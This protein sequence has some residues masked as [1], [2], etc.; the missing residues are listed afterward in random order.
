MKR[1][2]LRRTERAVVLIMTVLVLSILVLV[3]YAFSYGAGVNSAAARNVRDAARLDAGAQSA[4]N[5]ACSMLLEKKDVR[6]PDTLGDAWNNPGM[7]VTVGEDIFAVRIVDEERKLNLNRAALP[8]PEGQMDLRGTL[9]R[10]VIAAGGTEDDASALRA[11]VDPA[12]ESAGSAEAPK[13]PLPVIEALAAIP[14]LDPKMLKGGDDC[15]PLY[16]LLCTHA[17]TI[18]INTAPEMLLE[19]LWPGAGVAGAVR[20]SRAKRPFASD[21]DIETFLSGI[22]SPEQA[23]AYAP[24]FSVRSGY[25]RIE[26]ATT[27]APVRRMA[28]LVRRNGRAI[29]ILSVSPVK[30]DNL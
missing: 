24:L 13:T 30:E 2:A 10:L 26:V 1:L 12:T 18:N 23:A 20:E 3:V 17:Q 21:D 8:P 15:T 7:Q 25:F 28:A 9:R 22:M 19:A 27:A 5:M 6:A 16:E 29:E 14:G 4:I 11:W